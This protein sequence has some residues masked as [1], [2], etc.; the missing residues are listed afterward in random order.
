MFSFT[1]ANLSESNNSETT[2]EWIWDSSDHAK[3]T[4]YFSKVK[5][6]VHLRTVRTDIV[7]FVTLYAI[8]PGLIKL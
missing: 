1:L 4:I 3:G 2:M 6:I 5:F 7:E 8:V